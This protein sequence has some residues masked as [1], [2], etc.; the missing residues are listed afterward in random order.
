MKDETDD[1]LIYTTGPDKDIVRIEIAERTTRI[2]DE[3]FREHQELE[4]V[5]LS[6]SV[7]IIGA[8]AFQGCEKLK[9]ILYRSRRRTFKNFLDKKGSL[10]DVCIRGIPSSVKV[11]KGSAFQNCKLLKRLGLNEGLERIG[12]G[13]F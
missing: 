12:G 1:D 10:F 8:F 5:T 13:A 2:P 4:E 9:S 3:A 7:Q 6:S 11:I